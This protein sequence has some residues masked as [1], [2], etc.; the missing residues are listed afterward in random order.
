LARV[1]SHSGVN[2]R[3]PGEP[4]PRRHVCAA[5]KQERAD[6]ESRLD[7]G[8][9]RAGLMVTVAGC[10]R[11]GNEHAT[12]GP[13]APATEAELAEDAALANE[14]AAAEAAD[15]SAYGGNAAAAETNG[16]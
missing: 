7:Q 12:A 16:Q 11:G 3:E 8:R 5:R 15:T 4:K 13:D 10:D 1:S 2:I 9:I 14:A 6:G